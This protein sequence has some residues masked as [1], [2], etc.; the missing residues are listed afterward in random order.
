MKAEYCIYSGDLLRTDN[1]LTTSAT[2]MCSGYCFVEE[3]H[4]AENR[5]FFFEEHLRQ[6]SLNMDLLEIPLPSPL[7][8]DGMEFHRL[9]ARLLNKN[10]FY[11]GAVVKL[12]ITESSWGVEVSPLPDRSYTL[13]LEGI[14]VDLYDRMTKC[15]HPLSTSHA[16]SASIWDMAVRHARKVGVDTCLIR[17]SNG[18]MCEAAS[19]NLFALTDDVLITSSLGCG[20]YHDVIREKIMQAARMAD[21]QVQSVDDLFFEQLVLSHEIFIAS[22]SV[23]IKWIKALRERR[24]YCKRIKDINNCLNELV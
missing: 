14:S 8:K 13:D 11:M 9:V 6:I 12:Y 24:Y 23:G 4:A 5:I 1:A 21:L 16:G 15:A 22:A 20:V 2:G 19:A 18:V 17:N 7:Q 3:M 10:R